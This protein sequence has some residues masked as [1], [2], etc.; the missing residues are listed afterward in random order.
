MITRFIRFMLFSGFTAFSLCTYAS[1]T[2]QEAVYKNDIDSITKLNST[3]NNIDVR[4]TNGKT[5][6]MIAAKAGNRDLVEQLLEKGADANAENINGGTA[7]MF[8]AISGSSAI[9]REILEH[10]ADINARGSNGWSALMVSAAKGHESA[11]QTILG[12]GADINTTDIYLWT[13]LM[14][15]A[16]ENQI[17]VIK[18][19]LEHELIDIHRQDDNGAT[20]LHHAAAGGHVAIAELLLS[21]GMNPVLTDSYGK[22]SADYAQHKGFPQLAELLGAAARN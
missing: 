1:E 13:P 6:L 9:I 10:G 22:S 20:A 4:G 14:R 15:A 3:A 19:L 8:A 16:H 18:I 5:A 2:F 11:T 12:A 7:V 21:A 17:S